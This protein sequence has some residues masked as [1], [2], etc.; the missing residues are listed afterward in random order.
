MLDHDAGAAREQWYGAQEAARF[1]GVHRSTL[2]IA[3]RQGLIVPDQYT[4]G[5]HARFKRE[6]LEA[7]R[8]RISDHP[9]TSD[10]APAALQAL[11]R[12]AS[13]MVQTSEPEELASV[14]L[15]SIRRAMPQMDMCCIAVRTGDPRDHYHMRLLAQHGLPDWVISDYLRFRS[16][17]RFATIAALRSLSPQTCVDTS[18]EQ[19]YSGTEHLLKSLRLGAY[20]IQPILTDE[21][22]LGV[23]ICLFKRPHMFAESEWTLMKGVADELAAALL[24]AH[25]LHSLTDTLT[26]SRVLMRHALDVRAGVPS[27][28]AEAEES[29]ASM[30]MPEEVMGA[31]FKHLSGAAEVCAM[32]FDRDLY[33]TNPHLL[34]IVCQACAGDEMVQTQWSQNGMPYTGVGASIPLETGLRAGVAAAWPGKR[35]FAEADHTLLV[36]FAGAYVAATDLS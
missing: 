35:H 27:A 33:T 3:V 29:A 16:T 7:F 32:G 28:A 26:T 19:L 8:V 4:P 22:P 20:F 11:A 24:H 9:A 23:V 25:Q 13:E 34:D 17:F 10:T 30:A 6:T 2:H 5:R 36:T 14:A 12:L 18:K 15:A 31:L 1:L 21:D